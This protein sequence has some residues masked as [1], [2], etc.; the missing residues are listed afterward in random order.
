MPT[1]LKNDPVRDFEH[2]MDLI[3]S[4]DKPQSSYAEG[5]GKLESIVNQISEKARELKLDVEGLKENAERLKA[6]YGGDILPAL[7]NLSSFTHSSDSRYAN[8]KPEYVSAVLCWAS[9]AKDYIRSRLSD[10]RQ[11]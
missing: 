8:T 5:L 10:L 9:I 11:S 7:D 1:E 2:V 6:Q 3:R 4:F